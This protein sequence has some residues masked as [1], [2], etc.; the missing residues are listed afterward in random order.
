MARLRRYVEW[1]TTGRRTDR[2][3]YVTKEWNMPEAIARCRMATRHQVQCGRRA[4]T[5]SRVEVCTEG[6][7]RKRRRG[8]HPER[9]NDGSRARAEGEGEIMPV[10][11]SHIPH[12]LERTTLQKMNATEGLLL[13]QL[14][15]A[16][17]GTLDRMIAKGWIEKQMDASGSA[18][19]R[20]TPPGE[21]ALKAKIPDPPRIRKREP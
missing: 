9:Q 18:S 7:A 20:I 19:Y 6:S 5:R 15:P 1:M 3:V 13:R 11:V 10:R 12:N 4:L 17:Q 16:G 8:C 21:A 2:I 14:Y